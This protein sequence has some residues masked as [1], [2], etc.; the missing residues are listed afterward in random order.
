MQKSAGT[1]YFVKCEFVM[2]NLTVAI[3]ICTIVVLEILAK[4]YYRKKRCLIDLT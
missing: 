2:N 4:I 1:F 3:Y